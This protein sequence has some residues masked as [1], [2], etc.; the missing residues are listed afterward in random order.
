MNIHDEIETTEIFLGGRAA[1]LT[2]LLAQQL[3]QI[4]FNFVG[5]HDSSTKK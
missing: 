4:W 3:A 5:K 1:F 2:D